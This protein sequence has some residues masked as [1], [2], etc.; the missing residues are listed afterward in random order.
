MATVIEIM[1][2]HIEANGFDGLFAPG[3]CACR[4]DDLAPCGDIHSDCIPGYLCK[5]DCGDHEF[6]IGPEKTP[7]V[8][9]CAGDV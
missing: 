4:K 2:A 7:I 6:H 1:A 3:E 5:C 9:V 8:D